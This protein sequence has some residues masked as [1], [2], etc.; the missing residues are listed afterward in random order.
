MASRSPL[1]NR[2]D[3]TNLTMEAMALVNEEIM[4]PAVT[5]EEKY[6]ELLENR[7]QRKAVSQIIWMKSNHFYLG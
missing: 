3:L 2:K 4:G 6:E 1:R 5:D 7:K